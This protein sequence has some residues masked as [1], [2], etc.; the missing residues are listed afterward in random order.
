MNN[1]EEKFVSCK[2]CQCEILEKIANKYSGCCK[3]CYTGKA[4]I[5]K[6]KKQRKTIDRIGYVFGILILMTIFI[7][8]FV[9]FKSNEKI[10]KMNSNGLTDEETGYAIA[11]AKAEVKGKLKSP[12]SAKFPSSFSEYIITK[13]EDTYTVK[14]YVEASNSF[15]AML[16]INYS[17]QFTM[18]GKETYK[19]NSVII[20]E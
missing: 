1:E 4:Y 2:K 3:N 7:S 11:V 19:V 17:I 18:T 12:S 5:S 20:D 8:F 9:V 10:D 15:G 13:T 6:D 14:S 16:K